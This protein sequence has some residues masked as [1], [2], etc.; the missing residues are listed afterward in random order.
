MTIHEKYLEKC[1]T[2]SDINQ[3]LPYLLLYASHCEHVTEFGVRQP[4]STYALLA[5]KAKTVFSYDIET[6]PEV[7]ECI[8]LCKKE[9]RDWTFVEADVLKVEIEET[10]FIWI[11]TFHTYSQLKAE[12][13]LHAHKAR[14][15][16]GFHDTHTYG[17]NGEPAYLKQGHSGMNDGK[18]LLEA[19]NEFLV[20]NPDWKISMKKNHNNGITILERI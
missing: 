11:D 18:G 13:K 9:K 10:D 3:L 12:L 4:T 7:A 20:A 15:Y 1:N 14:K 19:I 2:P 16:I 8:A 17:I 5:S 6:Q